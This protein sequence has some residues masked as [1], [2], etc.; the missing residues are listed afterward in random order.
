MLKKLLP[1]ILLFAAVTTGTA[2]SAASPPDFEASYILKRGS[3][4]IGSSNIEF[5][6]DNEGNYVY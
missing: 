3:L 2:L 4:R 1:G 6:S 5:R